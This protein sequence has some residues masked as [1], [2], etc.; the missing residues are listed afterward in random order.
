MALF[1]GE[2]REEREKKTARDLWRSSHRPTVGLFT[3]GSKGKGET[4][5]EP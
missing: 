2:A 5:L 4:G 3:I 1:C